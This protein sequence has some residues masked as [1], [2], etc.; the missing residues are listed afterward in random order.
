[1]AKPTDQITNIRNQ[2]ID[3]VDQLL[4]TT[5]TREVHEANE[6]YTKSVRVSAATNDRFKEIASGRMSKQA[7]VRRISQWLTQQDD[8]TINTILGVSKRDDDSPPMRF[9]LNN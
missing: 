2:L 3:F 9:A 7:A 4:V 8:K 6:T 1:M 5:T